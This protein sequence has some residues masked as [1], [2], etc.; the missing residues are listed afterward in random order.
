MQL[1][2]L[3]A[4]TSFFP[5]H[6]LDWTPAPAL[7][8]NTELLKRLKGGRRSRHGV[9][10]SEHSRKRQGFI[11]G[12]NSFRLTGDETAARRAYDEDW[13]WRISENG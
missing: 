7:A 12:M 1:I 10:Q 2:D 13:Q 4:L 3:P 6:L 8:P 11:T 5:H 9:A